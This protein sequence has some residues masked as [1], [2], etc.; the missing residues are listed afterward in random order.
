[1][2]KFPEIIVKLIGEDGNSFYIIG[3]VREALVKA[4]HHGEA[5]ELRTMPVMSKAMSGDYNNLLRTACEY[6]EVE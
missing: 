4:G 2:P 1:M 5:K 3:K 6:V